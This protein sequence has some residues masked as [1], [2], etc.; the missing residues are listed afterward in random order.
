M[1]LPCL[2]A[3]LQTGCTSAITTAYLR[4]TLFEGGEHAE[5]SAAIAASAEDDAKNTAPD[6]GAAEVTSA[7]GQPSAGPEVD[8]SRRAA[9]IEEAVARLSKLGTL[10]ETA[11]ATLIDTLRRTQQ[12]DW[13]VVIEA[14]AETLAAAAPQAAAVVPA[15]AAAEPHVV[16]KATTEKPDATPAVAAAAPAPAAPIA[17]A[18]ELAATKDEAAEPAPPEPPQRAAETTSGTQDT[19][20]ATS[21]GAAAAVRPALTVQNAAFASKVRAWGD[22]DRFP[23]NRFRPGQEVIVYFELENLSAGDSP[24]GHTTCIDTV[25]RLVGPSGESVHDW[26]FEPIAETL[27]ARR[28]D[29][30]ARY[31]VRIPESTPAGGCRLQ[32]TVTDTLAG[33]TSQ[34]SL[35]LELVSE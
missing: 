25:I 19:K 3:L 32:L 4:D 16:A 11:R 6:D 27:K 10:D 1:F 17:A 5:E 13:P 30:F 35:P 34:A 18:G 15:S 7:A 20:P 12:E 31:V 24:A 21:A 29:Y 26:S 33:T 2:A 9:A 28:R 23:A 14:F 22:L 8:A